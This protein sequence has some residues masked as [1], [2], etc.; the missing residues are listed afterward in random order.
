MTMPRGEQCQTQ[1]IVKISFHRLVESGSGIRV[2]DKPVGGCDENT[3]MSTSRQYCHQLFEQG[4][5]HFLGNDVTCFSRAQLIG[6]GLV[7]PNHTLPDDLEMISPATVALAEQ[8]SMMNDDPTGLFVRFYR[9][10]GMA[11]RKVRMAGWTRSAAA[12]SISEGGGEI[13]PRRALVR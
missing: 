6:C 8:V 5:T 11:V 3:L 10:V 12:P 1:R 7:D 2:T 4:A 13:R 9:K